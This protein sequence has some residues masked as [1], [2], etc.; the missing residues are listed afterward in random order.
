MV[1]KE[2][3]SKEVLMRLEQTEGNSVCHMGLAGQ[4][5]GSLRAFTFSNIGFP[6]STLP[7]V[8]VLLGQGPYIS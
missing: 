8:T 3:L 5:S 2:D 7:C 4:Q 1:N 6:A